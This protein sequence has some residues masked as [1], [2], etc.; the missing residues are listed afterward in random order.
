MNRSD[1][2]SELTCRE[3]GEI[4]SG[5]SRVYENNVVDQKAITE[6][7]RSLGRFLNRMGDL[8]ISEI[9]A[10]SQRSARKRVGVPKT[11]S[12]SPEEIE[13]L[14]VMSV[15]RLLAGG[16]LS[17]ADLIALALERFGMGRGR[18]VKLSRTSLIEAIN[19][20]IENEEALSIISEEARRE[21]Q[22]RFPVER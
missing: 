11:S 13:A 15:R 12:L 8:R 18:L 14:D 6:S 3:L 21:G 22:Q 10:D 17:R 16:V 5:F 2:R 7:L 1:H 20:A 9:R 19:S 4:I